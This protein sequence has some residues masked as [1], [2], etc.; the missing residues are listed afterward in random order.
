MAEGPE[1]YGY[2]SAGLG[3]SHDYLLPKVFEILEARDKGQRGFS[4]WV[5]AMGR[6]PTSCINAA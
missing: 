2:H 5:A 3:C 6:S 4:S 1:N